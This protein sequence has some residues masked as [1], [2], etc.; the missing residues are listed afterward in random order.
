[1]TTSPLAVVR[2]SVILY[3]VPAP[4]RVKVRSSTVA[5]CKQVTRSGKMSRHL[6]FI[7]IANEIFTFRSTRISSSVT[8]RNQSNKETHLFP[9]PYAYRKDTPLLSP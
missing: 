9:P 4:L 8:A 7:P 1:M 6:N 5:A 2:Q 3:S